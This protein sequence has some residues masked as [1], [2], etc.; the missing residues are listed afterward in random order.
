MNTSNK[1]QPSKPGGSHLFWKCIR[2]PSEDG[3]FLGN[4]FNLTMIQAG[5]FGEGTIFEHVKSGRRRIFIHGKLE[6]PDD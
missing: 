4:C 3:L 2:D 6:N 5:G 1:K